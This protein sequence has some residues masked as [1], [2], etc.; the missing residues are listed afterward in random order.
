MK[1]FLIKIL[2]RMMDRD[3]SYLDIN[4][5]KAEDWLARNF[6]DTGFHEYFRKRDLTLLK[7]MATGLNRD[8]YLLAVGQRL[9]L[10]KL[11]GKVDSANKMVEKK[12]A[13]QLFK[14]N[15][16]KKIKDK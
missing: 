6:K 15:Q 4:D 5:K 8:D 13:E 12:K 11:L 9:E 1:R 2:F 10:L 16:L 3:I 14:A 7:T